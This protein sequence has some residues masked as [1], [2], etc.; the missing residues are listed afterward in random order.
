MTPQTYRTSDVAAAAGVH[1]NTVRRYEAWG[2]LSSIPR[3]PSGYRIF[4]QDHIDQM[5]LA[6]QAL[7]WPYPGGKEP[8]LELVRQAAQGAFGRAM[9]LS[10]QVLANV[11]AERASA[12]AA[13]T[14]LEKWATGQPIADTAEPMRIGHA[15]QTLRVTTDQLR[16]WDRNGLLD[17]PRDP[18]NGY[19]LYGATELG[20]ARVIHVLCQAGYSV[21]AIL[22]MVLALDTGQESDLRA[23][24]DSPPP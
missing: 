7:Q 13:V 24:L 16:N 3:T 19:R 6:R 15:A 18:R 20:R 2:L 14:F 8:V 12:E 21:M 9:E 11:R 4:T 23:A 17:V 22:R 10:H 5:C 1:P